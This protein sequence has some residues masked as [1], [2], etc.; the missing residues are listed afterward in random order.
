M[1]ILRYRIIPVLQQL[2]RFRKKKLN[3]IYFTS[4]GLHLVKLDSTL[5]P[6]ILVKLRRCNVEVDLTRCETK[7]I[8][9]RVTPDAQA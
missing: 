7:D 2:L 9:Y 1:K 8:E 5:V 4:F 3:Y 6:N